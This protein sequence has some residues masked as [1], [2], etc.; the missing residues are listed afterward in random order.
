MHKTVL[1]K[2]VLAKGA[3]TRTKS[4]FFEIHNKFCKKIPLFHYLQVE[5]QITGFW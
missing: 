3:C 1:W 4:T 5:L 2:T